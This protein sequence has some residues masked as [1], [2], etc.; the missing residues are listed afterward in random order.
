MGSS[1]NANFVAGAF[2]G[3]LFK[4]R[5]LYKGTQGDQEKDRSFAQPSPDV[6]EVTPKKESASASEKAE[7]LKDH[8]VSVADADKK[9]FVSKSVDKRLDVQT[10]KKRGRPKKQVEEEE[11]EVEEEQES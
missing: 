4:A 9:P 7:A 8:E 3:E 10:R 1:K 11:E 5:E 6:K 2:G